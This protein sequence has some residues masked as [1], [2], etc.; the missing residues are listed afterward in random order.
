MPTY[1]GQVYNPLI[2]EVDG[3]VFTVS[4]YPK[5]A[6]IATP[7]YNFEVSYSGRINEYAIKHD[8]RTDKW[9]FVYQLPNGNYRTM[10]FNKNQIEYDDDTIVYNAQTLSNIDF[11]NNTVY[12]PADGKII[13]I[14][15]HKNVAKEFVCNVVD[16]GSKL[17]FTGKG[18]R[19]YNKDK[20]YNYG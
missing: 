7:D 9:L 2:E 5:T 12:D 13:G 8:G 1:L 3:K 18:F 15:I 10:M 11:N 17:E 19:I 4:T 20:I 6:I 16:E 14:N